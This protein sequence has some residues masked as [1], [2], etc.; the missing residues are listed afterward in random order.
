MNGPYIKDLNNS[1]KMF[2]N[3]LIGLI[4]ILIYKLYLTKINGLIL[5]L[6]SCVIVL[7]TNNLV[8]YINKSS[9]YKFNILSN[10]YSLIIGIVTFL[11]VPSN[12]SVMLIFLA[13]IISISI[14]K[15]I[16][17]IN[18]IALSSFIIYMFFTITRT[19]V[20]V[21][22]YNLYI[23]IGISIIITIYLISKKAIKF[24]I[25]FVFLFINLLG[26]MLK[27]DQNILYY[28]IVFGLFIIPELCSTPK[29][30]ISQIL[31]G[32]ILGILSVLLPI[33]YFILSILIINVLNK[34]IDLYIAYYLAN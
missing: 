31:Y 21:P 23:L 19:K 24:R 18:P 27:L 16:N 26:F 20:I 22:E 6:V 29:L 28:I 32:L 12:T 1:K 11:I 14:F 13:N 10:L 33:E 9:K 15:F 25:L 5:L 17:C 7:L 4:P 30:A 34:Y 8:E 2:L 3:I